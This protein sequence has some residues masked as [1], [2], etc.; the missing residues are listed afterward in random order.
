RFP[1]E[2]I[3]K[4]GAFEPPMTKELGI[5][6]RDN[7]RFNIGDARQVLDLLYPASNEIA[8]VMVDRSVSPTR[9]VRL[10][11]DGAP[12]DPV[13]FDTGKLSVAIPWQK[14]AQVILVEVKTDVSIEIPISWVPGIAFLGAPDLFTGFSVASENRW[15]R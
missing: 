2:Q 13:I 1:D 5:K 9:H 11:I 8:R 3:Q 4:L 6:G 15:A 7:D 10:L 14:R 12:G